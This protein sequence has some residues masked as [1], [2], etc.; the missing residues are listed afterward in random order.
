MAKLK[1]IAVLMC[2]VGMAPTVERVVNTLASFQGIVD[3]WIE[4]YPLGNK[5]GLVCNEEGRLQ[6]R[7]AGFLVDGNPFVG[8]FFICRATPSGGFTSVSDKEAVQLAARIERL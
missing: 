4:V 8:D 5:L 2:R 1:Q 7:K 6:G 3:G